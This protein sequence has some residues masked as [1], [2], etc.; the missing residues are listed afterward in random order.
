MCVSLFVTS[1]TLVCQASLSIKLLRQEYW[2]GFSLPP[3]GDL[4]DPGIELGSPA[5]PALAGGFFT[6]STAWEAPSGLATSLISQCLPFSFRP[7]KGS[8]KLGTASVLCIYVYV[9]SADSR[10]FKMLSSSLKRLVLIDSPI[11]RTPEPGKFQKVPPFSLI[12]RTL[13]LGLSPHGC[14]M[15]R[16]LPASELSTHTNIQPKKRVSFH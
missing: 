6:T 14:H 11:I 3:S 13:V 8:R 4:P 12:L 10:W 16:W 7:E 2:S 5:S 15:R 1:R 9:Y